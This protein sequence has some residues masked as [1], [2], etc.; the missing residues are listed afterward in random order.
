MSKLYVDL[1]Y[2]KMLQHLIFLLHFSRSDILFLLV[3]WHVVGVH[4][5]TDLY[6]E[7]VG[8][9]FTSG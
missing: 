4:E 9:V 7:G 6:V 3:A 8:N 2:D 5:T 1:C